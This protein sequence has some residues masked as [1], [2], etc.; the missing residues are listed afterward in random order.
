MLYT[1]LPAHA[2][3]VYCSCTIR[4]QIRARLRAPTPSIVNERER[5]DKESDEHK[6]FEAEIEEERNA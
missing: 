2:H 3:N 6:G 5:G 1:L 4:D